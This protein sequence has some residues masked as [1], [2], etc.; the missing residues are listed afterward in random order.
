MF[1]SVLFQLFFIPGSSEP[2]G[3]IPLYFFGVAIMKTTQ[4]FLEFCVEL[5]PQR[6]SDWQ[7]NIAQYEISL[8]PFNSHTKCRVDFTPVFLWDCLKD[9]WVNFI[10]EDLR[11][12]LLL[13]NH[14][15]TSPINFVYCGAGNSRNSA[16][17]EHRH[18]GMKWQVATNRWFLS[19]SFKGIARLWLEIL[20]FAPPK[21]TTPHPIRLS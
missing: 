17:Y 10:W 3:N 20:C 14:L 6:L 21:W 5:A 1:F 2:F 16:W 4:R 13:C 12:E 7:S 15:Q 19:H 9:S 18:S 11:L 8:F